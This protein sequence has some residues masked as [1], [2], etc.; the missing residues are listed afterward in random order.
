MP[1]QSICGCAFRTSGR[2][3][4]AQ[5]T[6]PIP[7]NNGLTGGNMLPASWA[8]DLVPSERRSLQI[9]NSLSA[10]GPSSVGVPRSAFGPS[11]VG[12][13]GSPLTSLPAVGYGSALGELLDRG[14]VT[15]AIPAESYPR[16]SRRAIPET[17][18]STTL[19]LPVAPTIPHIPP[20]LRLAANPLD[21]IGKLTQAGLN[22]SAK[23]PCIPNCA[24]VGGGFD[25]DA[26]FRFGS[27]RP[28]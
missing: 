4:V 8:T 23:A 7:A 27:R 11:P 20:R 15:T 16:Y 14:P 9:E 13:R 18:I 24:L 25:H 19:E 12:A 26:H 28:D 6:C 3:C 21:Q 17:R 5:R 22:N 10:F 1:P 2:P